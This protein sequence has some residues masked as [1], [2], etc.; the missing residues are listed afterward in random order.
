MKTKILLAM[1]CIL[2]GAIV[3]MWDRGA[4]AGAA[5]RYV[6]L[7]HDFSSQTVYWPTSDP[8]KLNVVAD[9]KT[10]KGYYY[11]ANKYSASEHGGTHL[12]APS[13][14]AEGGQSN[15]QIP[16]EHL[17]AP[18][19]KIDVS[20]KASQNRDYLISVDDIT[21]WEKAN[22]K[23]KDGSILLFETGYWRAWPNKV[24]YLGTDKL[25]PAG[26]AALHFPGIDPAAARWLVANRKIAAVGIDTASI[27]YGQSSTY[28]S[29]VAL[30]A[31]NI[32][33]F[34][35]VDNMGALPAKGFEVIALPMKIKGGS[36]GPLRI[37]A[38]VK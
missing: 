11:R 3:L 5:R 9:G 10:E 33:A 8:F 16:L 27:D 32:A 13:H 23:I 2:A 30:M 6:D 20:A 26:V 17:I 18:A 35:N 4:D 28:D 38:V 24:D 29:H 19:V 21:T 36:G 25:G 7:T 34:E 31:N 37:V 15:D 22:G 1:V 14:F 12:D